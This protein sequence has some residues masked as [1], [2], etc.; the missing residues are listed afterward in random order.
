MQAGELIVTGKDKAHIPLHGHPREINV[1]FKHCLEMVPCNPHHQDW[2]E[3]EVH[4]HPGH[5]VLIIKW[6]VSGVREIAWH[7]H[8]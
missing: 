7:A 6:H 4:T 2:L 3:Y 1:H 5:Y 8:Y